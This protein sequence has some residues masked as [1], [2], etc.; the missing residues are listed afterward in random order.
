MKRVDD[1]NRETGQQSGGT[2][3]LPVAVKKSVHPCH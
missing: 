3:F 1:D 2:Y